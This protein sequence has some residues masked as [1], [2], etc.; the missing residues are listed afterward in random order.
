MHSALRNRCLNGRATTTV[1]FD[2]PFIT[3]AVRSAT[4]PSRKG[5]M[6]FR[7]QNKSR[8][9]SSHLR[10]E[11]WFELSWFNSSLTD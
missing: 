2:D 6:N 1:F 3:N 7:I 5:S 9:E 10:L 11:V 4:E 8:A